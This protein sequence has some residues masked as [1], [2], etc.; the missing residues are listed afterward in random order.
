MT[1][2]EHQPAC[3]CAAASTPGIVLDP[4]I[5]SGTTAIVA[6]QHGR[7]WIG[8]E[9]SPGIATIAEQRIADERARH[10]ST[11][12]TEDGERRAA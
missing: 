5:G 10:A 8:I 7:K 2:G 6:E 11:L 4:F 1:A 9:L 3:D 12:T